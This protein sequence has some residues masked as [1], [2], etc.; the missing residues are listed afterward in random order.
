MPDSAYLYLYD[1]Y[2]R[3]ACGLS[4]RDGLAFIPREQSGGIVLHC[5][6]D[7]KG[8]PA[9]EL[10]DKNSK[11]RAALGLDSNGGPVGIKQM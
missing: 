9:I 10:L 1:R 5:G 11:T 6:P 4:S 3:V 8:A 7:G 2:G